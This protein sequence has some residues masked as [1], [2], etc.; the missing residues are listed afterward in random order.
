MSETLVVQGWTPC[1]PNVKVLCIDVFIVNYACLPGQGIS[2]NQLTGVIV[3]YC[4]SAPCQL[5]SWVGMIYLYY[6]RNHVPMTNPGGGGVHN[7][8]RV[9]VC[10]A[11]MGGFLGPNSLNKGHIFSADFHK[12][13]WVI[14]ELAKNSKKWSVFRQIHHISGYDGNFR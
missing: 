3:G 14:K 11:H 4:F 6:A 9:R 8:S 12:Q 5:S 13:G 1:K 2:E 10:A 7:M